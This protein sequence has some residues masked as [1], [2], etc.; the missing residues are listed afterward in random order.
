[1][2]INTYSETAFKGSKIITTAYSNSFS[3]AVKMLPPAI[4]KGIY[5][6]YGF[7]RLADEI[8]DSFHN[9]DKTTLLDRFCE[10]T[11]Y[12][13]KQGISVNP[14]IHCFQITAAKYGIGADLIDAFLSSM[15]KD[16]HT[17]N[18]DKEEYYD[19]IFGSADVVG[20]MCLKVFVEGDED[21]YNKLK[22]PA[23]RLGSAFQKVNFLRDIKNDYEKLNRKYF[24]GIDPDRFSQADKDAI[25]Q[26]I[27]SD[28]KEAYSGILLLPRKVRL[29][30]L[31]AYF[32]YSKLL[33]KLEKLPAA[34]LM[35]YRVSI[36]Q[37]KKLGI[38]AFSYFRFKMR[39]I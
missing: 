29:S 7:V 27:K 30:V 39:F 15:R 25:I 4:S 23:M 10:E 37:H 16:L 19:Y 2:D 21:A 28:F 32:Y 18:Y 38:L 35:Q 14:V 6:I 22:T 8:V 1:M 24:P 33:R 9:F 20:L 13:F 12:A 26:E 11:E 17:R 34:E 31:T 5:S 36:P 3:L